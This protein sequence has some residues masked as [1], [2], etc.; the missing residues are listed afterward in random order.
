MRA[1]ISFGSSAT[2]SSCAALSVAQ[3]WKLLECWIEDS[4]ADQLGNAVSL[5]DGELDF[6]MVKQNDANVA[7]IVFVDDSG[8]NV[9]E[10]LGCQSG[11]WGDASVAALGK[12]DLD[13]SLDDELTASR[14]NAVIG[15]VGG[16]SVKYPSRRRQ[17]AEQTSSSR[18]R[19]LCQSLASVRMHYP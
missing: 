8:S 16:K 14:N 2:E 19:R 7:A 9:D 5:S 12:L 10:V 13:V 3:G 4:L 1:N 6:R 15:A 17:K 11:A 18:I